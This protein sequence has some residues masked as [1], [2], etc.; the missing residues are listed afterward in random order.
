[1]LSKMRVILVLAAL[2]VALSV[3]GQDRGMRDELKGLV[4]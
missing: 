4:F 2:G 3:F 1:M